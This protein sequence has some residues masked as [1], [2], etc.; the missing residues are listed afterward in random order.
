TRGARSQTAS[1]DF[2]AEALGDVARDL[3]FRL[4]DL[5]MEP[6]DIRLSGLGYANL[7]YMATV[8]VELARARDSDLTLFLFEEPEAHL[9]PQLQM[10]VLYFLLAQAKKSPAQPAIAGQPEGGIQVIVTTHSQ[11]LPAW[12]SPEHLVVVRSARDTAAPPPVMKTVSIPI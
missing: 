5:D 12:V 2:T 4:A 7:L 1:L 3:R 8:I 10:L 9:H 11:N 6:Q